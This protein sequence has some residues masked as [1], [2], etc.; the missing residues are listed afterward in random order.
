MITHY[1]TYAN[2][3]SEKRVKEQQSWNQEVK[4]NEGQVKYGN[5]I[6]NLQ[7]EDSLEIVQQGNLSKILIT[8]THS[9]QV[10]TAE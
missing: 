7:V 9:V 8:H 1:L 3:K 10:S 6:R 4:F 5:Y 2:N